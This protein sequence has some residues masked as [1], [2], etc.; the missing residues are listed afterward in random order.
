MEEYED[1]EEEEHLM[2]EEEVVDEVELKKRLTR[3]RTKKIKK[4]KIEKVTPE[5]SPK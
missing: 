2:E 1:S 3:S 5:Y 4:V